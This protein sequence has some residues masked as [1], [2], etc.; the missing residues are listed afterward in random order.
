MNEEKNDHLNCDSNFQSDAISID[1]QVS[2]SYSVMFELITSVFYVCN[3]KNQQ[4]YFHYKNV[5]S[6]KK[7]RSKNHSSLTGTLIV[8]IFDLD[9]F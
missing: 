4:S 9:V 7:I 5:Y 2:L 8:H 6:F 1:F 3:K